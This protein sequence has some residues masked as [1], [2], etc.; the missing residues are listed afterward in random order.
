[1]TNKSIIWTPLSNKEIE[2]T[3]SRKL[4]KARPEIGTIKQ[5]KSG[6]ASIYTEEGWKAEHTVVMERMLGRKLEKWESVHHKN[7][8]RNDNSEENLELWL[9]GIRHGQR[10]KDIRC[11]HCGE[12]YLNG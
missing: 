1:M 2:S 7:G 3:L 6:Y 8:I 11:P 12:L 5:Y 4:V 9:Y 10:A